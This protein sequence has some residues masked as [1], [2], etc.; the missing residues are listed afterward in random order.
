MVL[1]GRSLGV[2]VLKF[3]LIVDGIDVDDFQQLDALYEVRPE[4][5]FS[6]RDGFTVATVLTD[7]TNLLRAV[8]AVAADVRDAVPGARVLRVDE[9][10][11]ATPDIARRCDVTRQA[12]RLWTQRDDF[13]APRGSVGNGIRVWDWA[14]VNRWLQT[15]HHGVLGDDARLLRPSEVAQ[16]NAMLQ[17]YEVSRRCISVSLEARPRPASGQW[18]TATGT[19]QPLVAASSVPHEVHDRFAPT[20]LVAG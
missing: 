10:L 16:V 5:Q 17:R 19:G 2:R 12:V 18:T 3:H 1:A 6:E 7:D 14:S 20:D 15:T 9:E 4:L 8:E 13:P 11:V